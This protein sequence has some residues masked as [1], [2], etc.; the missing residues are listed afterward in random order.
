MDVDEGLG[1]FYLDPPKLEELAQ[2]SNEA[3]AIF[4]RETNVLYAL[5]IP[6]TYQREFLGF[7]YVPTPE[8]SRVFRPKDVGTLLAICAQAASAIR[9]AQLFAQREEAYAEMER[10]SKLKDEFL[11]TAS[12]ELR[13]PLTA[14]SGYSSQLR[15]QASRAN[16]Q[17]VLRFAN[18]IA[19]AAQQLRDMVANMSD[20]VQIGAIDKNLDIQIEPVQLRSAAEIAHNMLTMKAEHQVLID[21][22]PDLW[23]LGDAPRVRQVL[24]N[25]LENAAKYSPPDTCVKVQAQKMMMSDVV[26]LLSEDQVDHALMAEQGDFPVVL[27]RVQDQGEGV[28]PEDQVRIFDKFVRAPRSLT[29]PVRGSGLGLYICRRFV[30]AMRGKL[31]LEQSII[32]QGSTFSFYLPWIEAPVEAMEE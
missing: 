22:Q 24:T 7:L 32:N 9:N 4:L 30:E 17:Q 19:V 8:N 16:P 20:A 18:K 29:T 5:V 11:V 3:G 25:L 13:T 23:I 26:T 28:L 14:I 12:H 27:V 21:I 10:M 6:F 31:W 15:R 1:F 2:T